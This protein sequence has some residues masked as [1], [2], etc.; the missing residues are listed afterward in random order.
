V[1]IRDGKAPTNSPIEISVQ[2]LRGLLDSAKS[3]DLDFLVRPRAEQVGDGSQSPSDLESPS[4]LIVE[5]AQLI[6]QSAVKV[7]PTE[8]QER[9]AEEYLAYIYAKPAAE[10][11]RIAKSLADGIWP[12]REELIRYK[13]DDC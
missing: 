9:Y 3:G 2:H 10:Q 5:S 12:L 7:L 11:I 6:I 1:Y 4:Q 8:W 13:T